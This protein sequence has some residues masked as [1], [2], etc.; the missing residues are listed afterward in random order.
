MIATRIV[1]PAVWNAGRDNAQGTPVCKARRP[2]ARRPLAAAARAREDGAAMVEEG[3]AGPVSRSIEDAAAFLA[4]RRLARRPFEALPAGPPAD[5][6]AAYA[7]QRR[8]HAELERRGRGAVVGYK[9]GC[10][11]P[12]MRRYLGIAT[13]CAGG[14]LAANVHASPAILRHAGFVRPGVECELAVRLAKPLAGRA[15]GYR[16]DEVADAVGECMAAIELVD[17]RYADWR[18]IGTPTLIADDFFQAGIVLGR[19]AADWRRHDLAALRGAMRIDGA[20]VG[21]G[22]GADV[23]GHPL[24]AL[25]WLADLL[26]AAGRP[27]GPGAVVMTG[28]IVQTRWVARGDAVEVDLGPL[29]RAAVRFE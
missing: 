29:G 1:V 13:P 8:L 23:M 16:P 17:D 27:L 10:T 4:E 12:V 26:A 9:I 20:A 15:G 21:E 5:E 28:S 19:P 2:A 24:A 22:S 18:T 7:I 11:T 3:S 14:V 6:A 25:A